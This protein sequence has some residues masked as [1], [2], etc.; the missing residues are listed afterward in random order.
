MTAVF[1]NNSITINSN[2]PVLKS[3][4]GDSYFLLFEGGE[5]V[6]SN[7][8]ISSSSESPNY[9]FYSGDGEVLAVACKTV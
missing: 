1:S 3:E 7:L 8:C 9:Y 2:G 4:D 5:Y 6:D